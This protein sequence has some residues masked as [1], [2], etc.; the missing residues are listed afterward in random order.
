VKNTLILAFALVYALQADAFEKV[1]LVDSFD[2][3]KVYDVETVTGNVQVLDHVL[4][5]GAN[6]ILWRNCSGGLMRYPSKAEPL[7]LYE[8]PFDELRIPDSRKVC[9]WFKMDKSETDIFKYMMAECEKRGLKKGVHWPFEEAHW[10]S[11]TMGPWNMQRPQYWCVTYDGMPWYVR[12]SIAFP[13]VVKH[14]LELLDE[15]LDRGA[16]TVFIDLFRTGG[17]SPACEYV[18]PV[19]EEWERRYP[20]EKPPVNNHDPRWL[21]TV[22]KFQHD[23][24]R[25]VRSRAKARNRPIRIWMS[26]VAAS[27]ERCDYNM[28]ERGIDWRALVKEGVLDGIVVMTVDI[29]KDNLWESMSRIYQHVVGECKGKAKVYMPVRAYNFSGSGIAD[30]CKFS[31]LSERLVA[32]KLLELADE[33][34]AD[35]I[36]MEC[37]DFKNYSPAV[38][39]EIRNYKRK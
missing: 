19:L 18:K 16:D 13:E 23:F 33:A 7:H 29:D 12:S 32:R 27:E 3:H 30:Y 25:A 35:G 38:C 9:G 37:V 17:W 10:A 1:A 28:K 4:L 22:S 34:G 8:F 11:W 20:G 31:G 5:T 15:V 24:L 2:F 21:S 39:E 14:K 36:A 6:S 26:I